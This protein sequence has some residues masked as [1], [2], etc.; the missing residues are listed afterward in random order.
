MRTLLLTTFAITTSACAGPVVRQG[1][2]PLRAPMTFDDDGDAASLLAAAEESV[3]Y[4]PNDAAL[5]ELRDFLRTTPDPGALAAFVAAR[6]EAVEASGGKNGRVLFTGYYEPVVDA[7]L[8]RDDTYRTPIYG[9]PPDLVQARLVDFNAKYGGD[10]IVGRLDGGALVPYWTRADI[11]ERSVLPDSLAIAWAK[12]PVDVFFAEVQGSATLRLA[13]GSTRRIGYVAKNGRPYRSVGGKLI[14]DGE[15]ERED[16]SMQTIRAWLATHGTALLSHNES[17]VF[18][19]FLPGAPLGALGR[20]VT[21]GRSIATDLSVFPKG[22]LAFLALE[23]PMP[24]GS[25][26]PYRRFV[27]N[28]DTGGAIVGPGRADIFF[29][30]GA[31]AEHV[32]GHLKAE[33][34]LVFF[35][36]KA[37]APLSPASQR[38]T[39]RA[40][41]ALAPAPPN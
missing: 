35:V 2:V 31:L 33:G 14:A 16:V 7:S 1:L 4:A 39:A 34:R 22:A 12:D 20:P 41:A 11:T 21:P 9:P 3:A 17:Y 26:K 18:F 15:I 37:R 32:A 29:G 36:P 24:D 30:Q 27:L 6:F 40:G 25:Q 28:Q 13:D 19:R 5:V 23:L 8:T 10:K 38:T